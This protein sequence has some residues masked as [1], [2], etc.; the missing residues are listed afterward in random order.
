MKKYLLFFVCLF[1][2]SLVFSQTL[3]SED[4]NSGL[5]SDWSIS[6]L[7][8]DGGWNV[9]NAASAG[10]QSWAVGDPEDG[11]TFISTNDDGCNCDKSE[12]RLIL[13]TVDLSATTG[14]IF[15]SYDLIFAGGTYGGATEEFDLEVSY[16]DGTTWE[17]LTPIEGSG[18]IAWRSTSL[19]ISS[20]GGNASVTL[21]FVYRDNNGWL[22][23]A[24]LDNIVLQIPPKNE[25]G[26][27]FTNDYRFADI[28]NGYDLIGQVTNFGS[29]RVTSFDVNYSIDG[30]MTTETITG[31]DIGPLENGEFSVNVPV[32]S[33][34]AFTIDFDIAN[35]NGEMD[36][37]DSNNSSTYA[38]VGVENA[39]SKMIFVEESTGTW[40]PWCPRG[41]VF[42]DRM[43]EEISD[44]FAGV[45]VHVGQPTW[46][47]PMQI[48]GDYPT[49][50]A[51]MVGGFPT[52][53]IDRDINPGIPGIETMSEF[54]QELVT[55][56]NSRPSPIGLN[57]SAVIDPWSR[58]MT[59]DL[60]A[61]AHTNID[62]NY[63][64][65]L[66]ITEDHVTG[67]GFDYRQA[68]NYAGGQVGPMDGWE[69][70]AN[71]ASGND[72]EY[73]HTLR[74]ALGGFSGLTGIIPSTL[75]SGDTYN[76]TQ[77]YTI[78]EEF[79]MAELNIVA[80]V[81]DQD[82]D[83]AAYNAHVDRE[84]EI[85]TSSID[86]ITNLSHFKTFPNPVG[87]NVNIEL[88]FSENVDFQMNINDALGKRVKSLG[89]YSES[90]LR[91]SVDVSDLPSGVYSLSIMTKDGQNVSK[92][93]KI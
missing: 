46:P 53:L 11:S 55:L 70:L 39:P 17:N 65:L 69:S 31:L 26:L 84:I 32:A 87:D 19:D 43:E 61:T 80:V 37:D 56:T 71:P 27:S 73:N 60:T 82:N 89:Q 5:P 92:F 13:P 9:G 50:Y 51:G 42:M 62:A 30:I 67:D 34:N 47:D 79:D 85:L 18:T 23:G 3:A 90:T 58:E 86:E 33:A 24:A 15:L 72:I 63:S 36:S 2:S 48:A 81:L 88:G 75:A 77:V 14:S 59:I 38:G 49:T 12:D 29:D 66:L 45:A 22:F 74:E 16:D 25:I 35:P 1:T 91:T 41:A 28:S 64:I 68:N 40:C 54:G 52:L 7:A 21:S 44:V 78:P 93:V 6:T 10:S 57:V 76:S 8:T 20:V 4:F 83:G